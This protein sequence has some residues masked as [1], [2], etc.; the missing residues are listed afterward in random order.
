[1]NVCAQA[2]TYTDLEDCL[3]IGII[4]MVVF[5]QKIIFYSSTKKFKTK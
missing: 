4:I 5:Q 1:M 2:Y 3:Y